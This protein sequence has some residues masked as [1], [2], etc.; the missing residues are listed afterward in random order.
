MLSP[1]ALAAGYRLACQHKVTVDAEV[2]VVAR[3]VWKVD[4]KLKA[5]MAQGTEFDP[6]ARRTRSDTGIAVNGTRLKCATSRERPVLGVALDIGTTTLAGYLM[7]LET[8][9][10][11]AARATWNPQAAYGADVISRIGFAMEHVGGLKLLQETVVGGLNQLIRGLLRQTGHEQQGI[12]HL[13]VA[14]NPTM[15]HIF[16]GVDPS[17]IAGAPYTPRFTERQAVEAASL[18]LNANPCALVETLP[19]VS[20]Y[21]GADTM[22]MA[23]FLRLDTR[24][25]ACLAIDVGTNGEILLARKGEVWACSAAA[26]PAFEGAR[27]THGMRAEPGAIDSV[28]ITTRNGRVRVHTIEDAPA[29]GI[30]GSGL[31]SAT[32]ALLDAG[33]LQT[34]GRYLPSDATPGAWASFLQKEGA[35][36]EFILASNGAGGPGSDVVL[37]QRDV[38]ELQLAKAAIAAG[39]LRLMECAGMAPDDV[40]HIYLAGAFGSHLDPKA[41]ERIGL[42]AGLPSTRVVVIGN[43]AGSGAKMVLYSR[44]MRDIVSAIA[45]KTRYVEL[46]SD[47]KFNDLFVQE[48]DFPTK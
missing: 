40:E 33:L 19:L 10:Q 36:R 46:S 30:S 48:M 7:N 42:L 39:I 28:A 24:T 20:G 21:V 14:G 5:D 25:E 22:A 2:E 6:P 11:E 3:V 38:R 31:V 37:T 47:P 4:W 16:L 23:L 34:S 29:R 18:G 43:A 13:T 32:A 44:Q 8:G 17:P 15:V 27:I 45:A 9:E 35:Q 12:Y 1:V 26:G 41:S